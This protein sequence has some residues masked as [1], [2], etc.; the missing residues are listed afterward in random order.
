MKYQYIKNNSK[1]TNEEKIIRV[2]DLDNK[3]EIFINN[4]S[5]KSNK[6]ISIHLNKLSQ[7]KSYE[8]KMREHLS[9]NNQ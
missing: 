2:N 4:L 6:D 7:E 8:N 1:L 3:K 5:N 9:Q